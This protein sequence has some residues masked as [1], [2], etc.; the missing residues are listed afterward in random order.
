MRN[1]KLQ[2]ADQKRTLC[3]LFPA[4]EM[5]CPKINLKKIF[6]ILYGRKR[7]WVFAGGPVVRTL[8]SFRNWCERGLDLTG[9]YHMTSL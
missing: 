5:C 1:P 9:S 6:D 8:L 2:K 3:F 7:S 4:L